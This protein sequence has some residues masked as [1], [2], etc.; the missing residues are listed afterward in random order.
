MLTRVFAANRTIVLQVCSCVYALVDPML[1]KC[2]T[3]SREQLDRLYDNAKSN[4]TLSFLSFGLAEIHKQIELIRHTGESFTLEPSLPV[5]TKSC[6]QNHPDD[7]VPAN[8]RVIPQ[9]AQQQSH[10][11]TEFNLKKASPWTARSILNCLPTASR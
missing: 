11:L 8:S 7:S 9:M 4:A 5:L 3:A 1:L 10:P 2:I 6:S